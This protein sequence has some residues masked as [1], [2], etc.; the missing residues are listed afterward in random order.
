MRTGVDL[1]VYSPEN[2]DE[3]Q[4]F[5]TLVAIV[6]DADLAAGS[7][8]EFTV[9]VQSGQGVERHSLT[10]RDDVAAGEVI[11]FAPST[12]ETS[13]H[14]KQ[15]LSD[16][17][18]RLDTVHASVATTVP[19]QSSANEQAARPAMA[20]MSEP[21]EADAIA[22]GSAAQAATEI[23]FVDAAV[24]DIDTILAN[25]DPSFQVHVVDA[26]VDGVEYM[27]SVLEGMSG[28]T[29]VHIIS[30]GSAGQFQLGSATV[31]QNSIESTYVDALSTISDALAENADL[32]IYGCDFARARLALPQLRRLLLPPARMLLPRRTRPAMRCAAATGN[33]SIRPAGSKHPALRLPACRT[34]GTAF[35]ATF[36]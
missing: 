8:L 16:G 15:I 12:Q 28:V 4:G 2:N 35:L 13:T 17:W 9:Q 18:S 11:V 21:D 29:A 19:G 32:L 27:A 31:D 25:I 6:P 3:F 30:H 7:R 22:A 10:L 33:L 26:G 34:T 24:N 36:H 23:V 1:A 5:V 14:G 20:V